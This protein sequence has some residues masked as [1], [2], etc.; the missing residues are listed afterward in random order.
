MNAESKTLTF[1]YWRSFG[2]AI[3]LNIAGWAATLLA[4]VPISLL[5]VGLPM[6]LEAFYAILYFLVYPFVG[7]P[8]AIR[9]L[10]KE[11]R[12]WLRARLRFEII[13]SQ[14]S[15]RLRYLD[16]LKVAWEYLWPSLAIVLP[17]SIIG[18]W[19]QKDANLLIALPVIF[20]QPLFFR[21]A[22]NRN[23]ANFTLRSYTDISDR[24]SREGPSIRGQGRQQQDRNL[25]KVNPALTSLL[26]WAAVIT[27]ITASTVLVI[28]TTD[29][30]A[31][32]FA[33][34]SE[35]ILIE[36]I[37]LGAVSVVLGLIWAKRKSRE[38]ELAEGRDQ[39]QRKLP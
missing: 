13:H 28:S 10:L 3:L 26:G 25:E 21:R 8:W 31:G 5:R 32:R 39:N 27:G 11:R 36:A 33:S 15:T 22:F 4:S 2:A 23:Y 16:S 20:L 1:S 6:S 29:W 12:P 19:V 14:A 9:L 18:M 37:L 7:L 34:D 17:G 30:T 24:S 35:R 38:R